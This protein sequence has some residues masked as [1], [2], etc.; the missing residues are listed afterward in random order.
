MG[1]WHWYCWN[2]KYNS[3]CLSICLKCLRFSYRQTYSSLWT[4]TRR[5]KSKYFHCQHCHRYWK[6][7]WRCL[8]LLL[9]WTW[10]WLD[11]IFMGAKSFMEIRSQLLLPR[12]TSWGFQCCWLKLPMGWRRYL[13]YGF[14]ST[15]SW[16]LTYSLLQS[17]CF[18]SWV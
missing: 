12:S 10:L 6:K 7:L 5:H 8:C 2:W 11:F 18:T 4:Q 1:T 9:R 14:V 3:K 17:T 15:C 13:R 16:W